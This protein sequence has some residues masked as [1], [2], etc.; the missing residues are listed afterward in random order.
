MAVAIV[1]NERSTI[2]FTISFFDENDDP[3][4]PTSATWTL[5]DQD[6]T[7]I[8]SRSDVV[9]SSLAEEVTIVLSGADTALTSDSDVGTRRLLVEAVYNSATLGNGLPLNDEQGF[10]V[11]DLTGIANA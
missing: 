7:V 10:K 4:T 5:T 6:G 9:I 1:V 8:N 2:A 11:K 3:V